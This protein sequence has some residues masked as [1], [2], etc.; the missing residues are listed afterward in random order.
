MLPLPAAFFVVQNAGKAK[1]A[2]RRRYQQIRIE[3]PDA[4]SAAFFRVVQTFFV[5]FFRPELP[6]VNV[7]GDWRNRR[8]CGDP[9][10]DY[11]CKNRVKVF[12]VAALLQA[13]I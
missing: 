11:R 10:R 12:H 2:Y 8:Y 3:L 7:F 13:T 5:P 4:M 1:L 9:A 6:S